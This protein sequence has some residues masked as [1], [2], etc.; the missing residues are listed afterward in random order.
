MNLKVLITLVLLSF[1]SV[2][3]GMSNKTI[4]YFNDGKELTGFGKITAN[5]NINFKTENSKIKKYDFKDLKRVKIYN[6]DD[7][8]TYVRIRV[9]DKS[10]DKVLEEVVLG[11]MNLYQKVIQGHMVGAPMSGGVGGGAPMMSAGHSYSISN[12]YVRR[13]GETEVTHLGSTNLFSKKFKK[14]A[15]EYFSDCTSL[16]SK[17]QS[18][19]FKKRHIE[20]VVTYYNTNCK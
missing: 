8:T 16:V 11:K 5:D 12:Y 6:G 14:A 1:L 19:K 3:C 13:A 15:S 9:A 4:L 17:I 7:V 18:R 10:S 2:S 20:E